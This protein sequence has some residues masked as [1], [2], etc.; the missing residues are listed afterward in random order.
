MAIDSTPHARQ[1]PADQ[2]GSSLTLKPALTYSDLARCWVWAPSLFGWNL[3][4]SS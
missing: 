4:P 1:E 2:A 3:T